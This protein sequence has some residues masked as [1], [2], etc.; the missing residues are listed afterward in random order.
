MCKTLLSSLQ[1]PQYEVDQPCFAFEF[2]Y[3]QILPLLQQATLALCSVGTVA[4]FICSQSYYYLSPLIMCINMSTNNELEVSNYIPTHPWPEDDS[5]ELLSQRSCLKRTYNKWTYSYM[6]RL[7]TK[8]AKQ[9]KDKSISAQ[10]K[11]SDLFSIP[12]NNDAALLNQRFWTLYNEETNRNFLE[13]LWRLVKS[14]FLPAGVYQLVALCAQLS[15]PICVMKLLQEI[16]A[17]ESTTASSSTSS[18]TILTNAI[19]YVI[20]IFILSIINALFSHRH[21]FLS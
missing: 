4:I 17:S 8:G 15:I 3:Y 21:Q 2:E 11:Q 13:T 6:N 7:F 20:L 10:L 9:R 18:S 1:H 19:P 12:K 14:T 5:I 16:E